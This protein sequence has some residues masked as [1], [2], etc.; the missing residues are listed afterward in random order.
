MYRAVTLR[1]A[2]VSIF[3]FSPVPGDHRDRP[4]KLVLPHRPAVRTV[5]KMR[6]PYRLAAKAGSRDAYL[7]GDESPLPRMLCAQSQT[8]ETHKDEIITVNA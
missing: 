3:C 2:A 1:A 8:R 7:G 4:T 6:G 5:E